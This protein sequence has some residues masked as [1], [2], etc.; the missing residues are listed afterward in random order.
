MTNVDEY[1]FNIKKYWEE[2]YGDLVEEDPHQIP[3]S[4]GRPVYVRCFVDADH[5]FNVIKKRFQSIILLFVNNALIDYF[6]KHQNTIK[7]STFG[8][9]LVAL[10]IV[11]IL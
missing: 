5:G 7:T 11:R 2:F 6:N 4:F 3:D 10:R 1:V 9:E 8:S